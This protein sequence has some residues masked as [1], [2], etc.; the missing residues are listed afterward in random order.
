M[1]PM[2]STGRLKKKQYLA[3]NQLSLKSQASGS[4]KIKR[5]ATVQ[6]C[7]RVGGTA[8]STVAL[9]QSKARQQQKR[10]R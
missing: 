3:G 5:L 8:D 10:H 7:D 2:V 6:L 9:G 4:F 1:C